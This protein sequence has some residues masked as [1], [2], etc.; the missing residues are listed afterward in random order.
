MRRREFVRL[1]AGAAMAWPLAARAQQKP[2]PVIG[3]LNSGSPNPPGLASPYMAAFGQGLKETGFVDGQNVA[4]EYRWAEGHYA[5][6]PAL[7]TDLVGR[8]VDLIAASGGDRSA[9]A[10]KNATSTIPIV[11][12][13]GGDPVAEGLITSLARP[14]GNLT[15]VAFIDVE[16]MPKRFELLSELVPRAGMIALLVN[17]NDANAER[18]I[19]EC[20]KRRAR[21]GESSLF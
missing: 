21:R 5:R 2:M 16:L 6:L 9:L 15:G 20:R 13:I 19:S 4:I 10:A 11:S 7:A 17:P 8:R 14:G 18:I 12:V 1:T 3:F